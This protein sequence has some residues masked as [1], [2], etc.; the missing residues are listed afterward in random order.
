MIKDDVFDPIH[1]DIAFHRLQPELLLQ[2]IRVNSNVIPTPEYMKVFSNRWSDKAYTHYALS[3]SELHRTDDE[4]L[5]MSTHFDQR[6]THAGRD[7]SVF[8][9]LRRY[10]QHLLTTNGIEPLCRYDRVLRWRKLTLSLG[11]DLFTA[12]FTAAEDIKANRQ[13]SN[14]NWPAVINTD[15][16]RLRQLVA[17]GVSENHFHL[18][19]S[20]RLFSLSWACMMNH[21]KR[22]H[23]FFQDK[24]VRDE[25]SER[26]NLAISGN[27]KEQIMS[28][29]ELLLYAAYLRANLFARCVGIKDSASVE[30]DFFTQ[31]DPFVQNQT[32]ITKDFVSTLRFSYGARIQQQN[33]RAKVLDYAITPE[34]DDCYISH[35]R[36]LAGERHFLYMCFRNCFNC[37][38]TSIEKD[39]F[40][41]Y[42]LIQNQFRSELIQVNERIGFQNFARYQDR[43]GFFWESFPEYWDESIRLSVNATLQTGTVR[44]LEARMCP[45][46][47]PRAQLNR[48]METDRAYGYG[49]TGR[50]LNRT[51]LNAIADSPLFYVLHF[52]KNRK[53]IFRVTSSDA[54]KLSAYAYPRNS[55]VRRD[56]EI[57]AKSIAKSLKDSP[58]LRK[59]I[60]G[61][62]ACS[63]EVGCRPETFATEFRFLRSGLP[64]NKTDDSQKDTELQLAATYHAGEDFI[65]I[66]DGI[67]A[68]DEAFL[69]LE[70]RRGDRLGHALALGVDPHEYYKLKNY[71][72]VLPK[73]DLLDNLIW[74]LFRTLEYG[75]DMPQSLRKGI[76]REATELMS[77]IGYDSAQYSLL[78]Y[79]QAWRLRGD[80]PR[81]YLEQF[82][83]VQFFQCD[84]RT[85]CAS[86]PNRISTRDNHPFWHVTKGSYESFYNQLAPE[87]IHY[88]A[89]ETVRSLCW[90]YH[91][92][93]DIKQNGKEV[94]AYQIEQQIVDVIAKI[95]NKM[96]HCLM[97]AGIS[98]E[99]NPSSNVLIGS[100]SKYRDHPM[101]RFNRFGIHVPKWD[102]EIPANLC[103]SINTDDQGVFDTSLESEYAYVARSLERE[104]DKNGHRINSND[105]IYAYL[106]H[107]RILGNSQTFHHKGNEIFFSKANEYQAFRNHL[108]N[109]GDHYGTERET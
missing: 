77:R 107:I 63:N 46:K 25:F 109:I 97:E 104:M 100:F 1:L 8:E 48:I 83:C 94:V 103:V 67:R 93:Y 4:A 45:S 98:I 54:S 35:N 79:F 92:D 78:E 61:I 75:I 102:H 20:T 76:E 22:I 108:L 69:F 42:L 44:S 41:L 64:C 66:I 87:L 7:A 73:Q 30:E 39:L 91:F 24:A 105:S 27:P 49:E 5:Y 37:S 12:A 31:F 70:L 53:E 71:Q 55:R 51:Q 38:F 57:Q 86:C 10:A 62:D 82:H 19:G 29:Q 90:L 34:L 101:F 11:Q 9:M 88:R 23:A 2:N 3:R 13:R 14:F 18:T 56:T 99:C 21:P 50:S 85:G 16:S 65:D 96:Q 72:L 89:D 26:L 68:I 47:N 17:Q 58:Y 40:Y 43:K 106:D 33:G 59:R 60:R 36:L 52:P 80:H 28:W 6:L 32:F 74:I 95:Q 15:N 84:D 81:S